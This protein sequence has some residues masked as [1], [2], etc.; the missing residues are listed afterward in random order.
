MTTESIVVI[1]LALAAGSLVKGISGLGLPLVA[2]PVMAG[3]L[4]V[5]RAVVMMVVPGILINFGLMWNYRAHAT[6]VADLPLFA[7]VAVLGVAVGAWVLSA[8]PERYIIV[9][10]AL[11]IG[12][13][14]V[15]ILV[16]KTDFRLP[17]AARRHLGAVVVLVAGLIQ[18]AT[19]ASGPVLATYVHA[20]KLEQGA[21]VFTVSVF[22]QVFMVT[23]VIA[24]TWL[25]MLTTDRLVDGLV[26]CVP[27]AI[28]L[29]LAVYISR[30]ISPR[31]F[32]AIIIVLLVVIEAR[33]I[34]KAFA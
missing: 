6:A 13:Y 28:F 27:V 16:V 2:I 23:Q 18:G 25:G 22:F 17:Q 14:L 1:F 31:R 29:P 21:F 12:F 19:G 33:L 7:A 20:L 32:N 34:M 4:G 10:M 5:E 24:F 3:F 15:R 30:F 26:A 8:V 11:W 9:F